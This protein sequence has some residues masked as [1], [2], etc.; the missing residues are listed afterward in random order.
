MKATTMADQPN[1]LGATIFWLYILAALMLTG[2][3][4]YTIISIPQ[5]PRQHQLSQSKKDVTI[6]ACLAGI[7]FAVLSANMLN[8]LVQS[9]MSWTYSHRLRMPKDPT[10]LLSMIWRWS[11]TSTLFEDFGKAIVADNARYLW[12]GSALSFTFHVCLY[13]GVEGTVCCSNTV[14]EIADLESP[15]KRRQIPRLWALFCLS[16]I[17]PISFTQNLFYVAVVRSGY[18]AGTTDI[19][20]TF[21]RFVGTLY[22]SCLLLAPPYGLG[23]STLLIPLILFARSLLF[24]PLILSRTIGKGQHSDDAPPTGQTQFGSAVMSVSFALWQIGLVAYEKKSPLQISSALF[25]HP[26]VRSLGCDFLIGMVS[27]AIWTRRYRSSEKEIDSKKA[28]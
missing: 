24:T 22:F 25:D 28:S 20:R 17:L 6:F 27:F 12:T 19:P 16:Q 2:L 23:T 9:F 5:K 1:Y 15:G 14:G 26:A 10:G 11:V 13:M 7:S 4:I 18:N 8:V 21:P 3:V